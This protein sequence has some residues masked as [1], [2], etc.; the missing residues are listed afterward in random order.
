M[1][2]QQR[3]AWFPPPPAAAPTNGNKVW[4]ITKQGLPLTALGAILYGVWMAVTA[5]GTH[6][7]RSATVQAQ[8]SE[9]KSD[10]KTIKDELPKL[11]ELVQKV[12]D[13]PQW[14]M[15]VRR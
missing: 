14:T 3:E 15:D 5:W 13:R 7:E 12:L 2:H 8:L 11:R 6:Q 9:L 1:T 10:V 4:D